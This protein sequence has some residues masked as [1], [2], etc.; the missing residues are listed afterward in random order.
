MN[1]LQLT[2]FEQDRTPLI[3]EIKPLLVQH[4][5]VSNTDED[6]LIERYIG[7]AINAAENY[8][9]RDVW[10]TV[11]EWTGDLGYSYGYAY[12]YGGGYQIFDRY[13]YYQPPTP[14][15]FVVR[16]GR[17]VVTIAD[18]NNQPQDPATYQLLSSVDPKTWGFQIS[19]IAQLT[20]I[21]VHAILGW[22]TFAEMPDD[23]QAF[24]LQAAAAQYE[25]RELANY[26][27]GVQGVET[28]PFI[29][30]YLLDSW[31]NLTYA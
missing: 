22:P 21:N 7:G 3:A 14:S 6:L 25:V 2:M 9:Q 31:A 8:L 23:L 13:P 12:G 19:A 15:D 17:A 4:A 27:A 24:I 20:G 5:R 16:R 10:P 29:P 30:L 18:A 28:A 1:P 26:G 11:R